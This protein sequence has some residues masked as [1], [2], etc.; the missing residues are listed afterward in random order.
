M[1]ELSDNEVAAL[2]AFLRE[3]GEMDETDFFSSQAQVDVL[4]KLGFFKKADK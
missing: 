2:L 4:R 3:F 1:I